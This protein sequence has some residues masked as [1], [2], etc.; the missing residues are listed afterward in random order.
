MPT[1]SKRMAAADA[2]APITTTTNNN[3]IIIPFDEAVAEGKDIVAKLGELDGE[4]TQLQLR[5]GELADKATTE[6]KEEKKNYGCR[7]LAKF[8]EAIG[9]V[10]CTLGRYR[11]VYRAW[12]KQGIRAPGRVSYSVMRALADHKDREQLVKDNP[13]LTQGEARKIA[14]DYKERKA[15]KGNKPE[16]KPEEVSADQ[17]SKDKGRWFK[18]LVKDANKLLGA[19]DIGPVSPLDGPAIDLAR[20]P[21]DAVFHEALNRERYS[22]PDRS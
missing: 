14:R 5:L 4:Q 1:Q 12:V 2:A 17:W 16:N 21:P 8:A 13:E 19:A 7:T 10:P 6:A 9:M 3:N 15:G 11:D 20:P 22:C 18:Q